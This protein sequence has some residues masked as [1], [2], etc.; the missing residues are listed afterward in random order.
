MKKLIKA[1]INDQ[2]GVT[3]IE[4]GMMGVALATTLAFIMGDQ[5]TG[6]V[7]ALISLY[8]SLTTAIQSA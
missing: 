5:N 7:S 8:Q 1:F 3:V 4:Y 2:K 6:F